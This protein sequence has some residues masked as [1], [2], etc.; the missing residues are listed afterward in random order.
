MM[1][2]MFLCGKRIV[3][4]SLI[5]YAYNSISVSSFAIVP[6]NFF[7]LLL[8]TIFGIPALFCLV[9]FSFVI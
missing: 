2:K 4:S 6:I 1:K 7:T 9:L 8:V 5:L 3:V